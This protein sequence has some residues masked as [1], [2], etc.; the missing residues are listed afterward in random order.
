[1]F[2]TG[3]SIPSRFDPLTWHIH[4]MLF[5]FVMA[6]IAGFLLTFASLRFGFGPGPIA[7]G[8][9]LYVPFMLSLPLFI[10]G[11]A[12][13]FADRAKKTEYFRLVAGGL[14]AGEGLVGAI[15]VLLAAAKFFGI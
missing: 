6:A 2:A 3:T 7:L 14:I 12:R 15:I 1:M 4:E 13:Y 9:G 5:G 10:G 11:I 8:I